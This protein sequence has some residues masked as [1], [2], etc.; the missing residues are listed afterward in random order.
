MC[1]FVYR[2]PL[3]LRHCKGWESKIT[4]LLTPDVTCSI[5]LVR[6]NIT[7]NHCTNYIWVLVFL[8]PSLASNRRETFTTK[9]AVFKCLLWGT[10]VH[11]HSHLIAFRIGD[12]MCTDMWKNAIHLQCWFILLTADFQFKLYTN[13]GNYIVIVSR[14]ILLTKRY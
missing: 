7:C 6:K 10:A 11:R 8:L 9:I 13:T 3:K 2:C 1:I 14:S 4:I 12:L 5:V